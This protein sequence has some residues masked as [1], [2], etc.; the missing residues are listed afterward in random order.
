MRQLRMARERVFGL[1]FQTLRHCQH[2]GFGHAAEQFNP[3]D[4]G[5]ALGQRAGLSKMMSVVW[6]RVSIACFPP[7]KIPSRAS[8]PVEA[9]SAVGV[10]SDRAQGR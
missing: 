7:I 3:A 6:E 8:V 10:A 4:G 9:A 1:L 5:I 2:L